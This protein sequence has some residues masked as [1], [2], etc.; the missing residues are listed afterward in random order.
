MKKK[1]AV[2]SAA[3]LLFTFSKAQS[4]HWGVKAGANFA[5][6]NVE[7]SDNNWGSRTGVHAGL[8][9][10][11]H[12]NKSWALQPE[13]VYSLQGAKTTLTGGGTQTINLHYLNVPVMLQYMF[14]NG[15]RLQT[16]PQAGFLLS[17]NTQVSNDHV[18]NT[19]S[20]NN[21]DFGWGF[22][23]GYLSNIGLGID[24]R[25]N[26]GLTDIYKPGTTKQTNSV[27]QLGLFYMFNHKSR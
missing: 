16:G 8:L 9:S 26:L 2:L 11:I 10:H 18:T 3:L 7:N 14:D 23:A 24:A 19:A 6:V 4:V 21:V 22:G 5:A 15:F 17:A 25:Y 27:F 20:Y 13:L 12:L 1:L